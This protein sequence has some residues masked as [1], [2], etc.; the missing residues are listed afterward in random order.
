MSEFDRGKYVPINQLTLEEVGFFHPANWEGETIGHSLGQGRIK[1]FVP[2][3]LRGNKRA[4]E[5]GIARA[6][7]A[8][9]RARRDPAHFGPRKV[10]LPGQEFRAADH[11]DDVLII[12]QS[13]LITR[14][15]KFHVV[16]GEFP[17]Q[18]HFTLPLPNNGPV[19]VGSKR[20][21][22]VRELIGTAVIGLGDNEQ[23]VRVGSIDKNIKNPFEYPYSVGTIAIPE[24]VRVGQPTHYFAEGY[25]QILHNT[26]AVYV[27]P[28]PHGPGQ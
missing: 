25:K 22:Y 24:V 9:R 12:E 1:T 7:D 15:D 10:Y 4:L 20:F 28:M 11:K 27:M 16:P 17:E 19:Y 23:L 21:H 2:I 5:A 13:T 8:D 14:G 18:P 26:H 6:T 3:S